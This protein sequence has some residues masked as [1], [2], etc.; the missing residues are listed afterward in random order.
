[1]TMLGRTNARRLALL[2]SVAICGLTCT[3]SV[4]AATPDQ[5]ADNGTAVAAAPDAKQDGT[6]NEIVVT[7]R[8]RSEN[9]QDVPATV[10]VIGAVQL[11]QTHAVQLT[12]I[13]AYVPGLQI[14]SQGTPGLATISIRGIA[15]L[16][17]TATTGTYIDESPLGSSTGTGQRPGAQALDLLPYDVE[18]IEVLEGPQGTLY[19][20][21]SLGGLVKYVLTTPH[22]Y[23]TD[24][25]IGGDIEGISGAHEPGGGARAM[26]NSALIEGKLGIIASGAF[27]NTPGYIDNANT[28]Q[29]GQNGVQEQTGRVTLL[30]KP[31]D[32]LS[33][34]L[35]GLYQHI[36]ADGN[37]LIAL[38]PVTLQ[39]LHGD[40]TDNNLLPNTFTRDL[41]YVSAEVNW[42]LEWATLLSA[43]SFSDDEDVQTIDYTRQFGEIFQLLAGAPAD[44]RVR[45]PVDLDLQKYTQEF[46]LSSPI[47]GVIEWMTGVYLD[48]EKGTDSQLLYDET[49]D[50]T[51]VAGQ[52]PGVVIGTPSTYREYAAFGNVTY[53]FT[54]RFDITGGVRFAEN[55]QDFGQV[56]NNSVLGPGSDISDH[57]SE[58]VWTYSVNPR[59][60]ITQDI[61]AYARIASGYQ[62]GGPNVS[63]PGQGVP[64]S[65]ASSTLENYEIGLK[66]SF[67]DRRATLN[68]SA[69]DLEWN[70]IQVNATTPSGITYSANGGTATSRGFQADG[71]VS[72]VDGLQIGG[73]V[74]Y[75]EAIFTEPVPSL[76][77]LSGTSIP[78][79]PRWAGAI[80]ADYSQPLYADWKGHIG[81]GLRLVGDRFSSGP[82]AA[83]QFKTPAYQALDLNM[84]VSNDRYT[85]RLF[86]KNLSDERGY[87]TDTSITSALTGQS[88]Q[89]E[90]AIIQPRTIG[91]AIDVKL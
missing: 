41:K 78:L 38:N 82:A 67:W 80:T 87:L 68:V 63:L 4:I 51:P 15:P 35:T 29:K 39:P 40:L 79:I 27:E 37:S 6:I 64:P 34:K 53:H 17:S 26:I 83:N 16:S 49:A 70:G 20:A 90:G 31:T 13:G 71:V 7:A 91:M 73:Q 22:L 69:F 12:D 2:T 36:N 81:V 43:S 1:M 19:G 8:K 3:G 52:N 5:P 14:D 30:Y 11:A 56:F 10:N 76:G 85:V 60:H 24:A 77:A 55:V 25:E 21:N 44:N 9:I 65:V 48:Y 84:D 54:D 57:S 47:G 89:V 32:D 72:P 62:P 50:G 45:F 75:T 61:M 66:S 23:D 88:V 86:A 58:G 46:R 33:I 18:R 42:D 74:T 28:G 59:F